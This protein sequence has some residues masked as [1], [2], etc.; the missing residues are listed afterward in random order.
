[1]NSYNKSYL[2]KLAQENGFVRDNLEKVMRLV[3]ILR[4]FHQNELLGKFLVLKGG[5]AINLTAFQMPR[6][7]V[8]IDLDFSQNCSKEDML[9]MREVLNSEILS[10]MSGEG[11]SLKPRSK[12]PHTLDSWI[13]GYINSGGNQDNIKIEINYSDR[14]HVLPMDERHISI[15][16]FGDIVINVLNPIELFASKL[17]AL[18]NR[19]AV[20]DIYD[21]YNMV[22]LNL[23]AKDNDKELLRKSLVFYIAV[24]SSCRAE[25]VSLKFEQLNK[26]DE[27]TYPQ[28]RDYLVPVLR[29]TDT[30][31]FQV[32][33]H[34]VS[35]FLKEF[36]VFSD[37]EY[38]FIEHFNQRDYRP[39]I[40]FKDSDIV[41]RI[42]SHPMALWKCR[43]K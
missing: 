28:V 13:F 9:K 25:E 32:A 15:E 19:V 24:G 33:K 22:R 4:Y 11:Y 35:D 29:R 6:L 5:T 1:M 18:F 41:N 16:L 39:D 17:N 23:F 36:L 43:N 42:A 14:C 7:S 30:F 8:D 3:D 20:R 37:E 27:L 38:Q 34:K 10:Y 2:D 12:N 21:I 31:D 40:L 26:I